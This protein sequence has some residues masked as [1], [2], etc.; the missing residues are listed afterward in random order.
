M[1]TDGDLAARLAPLTVLDERRGTV[2]LGPLW[3]ERPTVL[4]FV[5]HFG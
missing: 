1:E 3:G 2:A 5:R 4:S